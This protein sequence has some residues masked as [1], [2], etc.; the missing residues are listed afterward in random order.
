[1]VNSCVAL[2]PLRW[3]LDRKQAPILLPNTIAA[4]I[5]ML[6]RRQSSKNLPKLR[7]RNGGPN[8]IARRKEME[9]GCGTLRQ[10]WKHTPR[11]D[12]RHTNL[13]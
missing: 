5:L 2:I 11:C 7:M 12:E 9:S 6:R 10:W 1:M 13:G 3:A 8:N 4:E